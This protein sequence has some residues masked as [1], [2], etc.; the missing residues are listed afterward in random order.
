MSKTITVRTSFEG[1][2]IVVYSDDSVLIK[3]EGGNYTIG[4]LVGEPHSQEVSIKA[5][6]EIGEAML[7]A[8]YVLNERN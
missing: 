1:V 5:L 8:A 2:N 6:E 3:F 7:Y 4:D